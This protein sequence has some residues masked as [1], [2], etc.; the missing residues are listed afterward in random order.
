MRGQESARLRAKFIFAVSPSFPE[1]IV[2]ILERFRR[3][4]ITARPMHLMKAPGVH[5][6]N[7]NN[8]AR[9]AFE[10]IIMAIPSSS[11]D[12]SLNSDGG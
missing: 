9:P 3:I 11:T 4:F 8:N 5:N 1:V 2:Y 12:M 6:N 10:H 7:N